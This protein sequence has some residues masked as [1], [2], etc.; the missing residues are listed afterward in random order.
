MASEYDWES[1]QG[2]P[3]I[4]N[5][6]EVDAAFERG[7]RHLGSAVIGLAFACPLAEAAPRIVR[8]MR[9]SDPDQ[10]GFAFTAAGVAARL[11]GELTPELYAALRAEGAAWL[12]RGRHRGH[13]DIRAV[14]EAAAMVQVAEGGDDCAE[15]AG[16]LVAAVRG[17]GR[18][19]L[20][21]PARP[22]LLS[23]R[24]FSAAGV[25]PARAGRDNPPGPV[26][27]ESG[28]R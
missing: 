6:A 25:L 26:G 24:A 12:C 15:Q 13:A 18:G 5:P 14:R 10:R 28:L 23:G 11:N 22:P 3:H 8:A 27:P 7:E 21:G 4:D 16:G 1:G 17:R 19:C 20:A 2:V 9:L